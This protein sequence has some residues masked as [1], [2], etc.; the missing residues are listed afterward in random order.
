MG[1]EDQRL[2]G[3]SAAHVGSHVAEKEVVQHSM[4]AYH[5][6]QLEPCVWPAGEGV[7]EVVVVVVAV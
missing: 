2:A 1:D 4:A 6:P 3:E 5:H 7:S